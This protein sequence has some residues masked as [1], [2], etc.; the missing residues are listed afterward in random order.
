[1]Q[2]PCERD[3]V[4]VTENLTLQQR[5][6]LTA[7]AQ[8][9][10]RKMAFRKIHEVL[11]KEMSEARVKYFERKHAKEAAAA[12]AAAASSSSSSTEKPNEKTAQE[13]S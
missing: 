5:E 12:A 1:M 11:G 3:D 9:F 2:D 8:T 7:S 13:S 4:D 6:D 10:V